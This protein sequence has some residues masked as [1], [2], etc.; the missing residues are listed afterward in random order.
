MDILCKLL[1][2]HLIAD[3]MCQWPAMLKSKEEKLLASPYLYLHGAIH[4]ALSLLLLW[5]L[6]WAIPLLAVAVSHVVIDAL[7]IRFTKSENERLL[8]FIDQLAHVAILAAVCV[9]KGVVDSSYL[10]SI[11][12]FWCHAVLV[13]FIT[14]PASI[15][16]QK[17]FSRWSL[18]EEA[19]ESLRGVGAYIGFI[20]RILIYVAVV[21]AHWNMVGF[22]IA[23]KSVFRIGEIQNTK[24]RRYAEYLLVGNFLSM[25]F[26][27]MSGILFMYLSSQ[28]IV[29]GS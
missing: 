3:F 20:E 25:F 6:S 1:L 9:Y 17:I 18:P 24:D 8:F 10:P 26:A 2:A 28:S 22:L 23:A 7:K 11:E 27:I 19:G 13:F 4:F 15:F 21:S 12:S 16:I 29:S 14:F 5:D